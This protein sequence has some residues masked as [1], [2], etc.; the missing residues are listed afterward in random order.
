MKHQATEDFWERYHALPKRIRDAADKQYRLLKQINANVSAALKVEVQKA[1][2][3]ERL[4]G[5]KR[6]MQDLIEELLEAWLA[7]R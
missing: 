1:L 6:T 3:E 2:L 7:G 5:R 4:E